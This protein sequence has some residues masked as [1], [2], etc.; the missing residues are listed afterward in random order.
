MLSPITVEALREGFALLCFIGGACYLAG[1]GGSQN[2]DLALLLIGAAAGYA[3]AHNR[4]TDTR[5]NSTPTR[6]LPPSSGNQ[7]K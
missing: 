5:T 3:G 4:R 2:H 7:E 6:S 1:T